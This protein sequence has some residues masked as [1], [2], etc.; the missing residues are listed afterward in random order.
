MTIK[1]LTNKPYL[2][3][4]QVDDVRMIAFVSY[5]SATRPVATRHIEQTFVKGRL[6][7]PNNYVQGGYLL[8][9]MDSVA[10][11]NVTQDRKDWYE[12]M[13]QDKYV[14][15][16]YEYKCQKFKVITDMISEVR[17]AALDVENS[18]YTVINR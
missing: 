4:A 16:I 14:P 1:F 11:R 17:Q 13:K 15:K 9:I 6:S 5:T 2:I 7:K 18:G 8:Y 10:V 12:K 3:Y